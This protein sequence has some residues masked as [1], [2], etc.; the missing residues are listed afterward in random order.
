[1]AAIIYQK[2]GQSNVDREFW[3]GKHCGIHSISRKLVLKRQGK[4]GPPS[5]FPIRFRPICARREFDDRLGDGMAEACSFLLQIIVIAELLGFAKDFL[6]FVSGDIGAVSF[7]QHSSSFFS[8]LI[9]TVIWPVS[10][11]FTAFPTR[12]VRT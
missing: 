9:R 1:M 11:N 7:T 12:L 3:H 2:G 10:V 6:E 4:K 8:R 5:P